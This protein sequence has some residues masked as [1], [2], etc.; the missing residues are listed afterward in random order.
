LII[1]APG[2]PN[3]SFTM[4]T[5]INALFVSAA[6]VATSAYASPLTPE[7]GQPAS[8][9]QVSNVTRAQVQE[10]LQVAKAAG[11]VTFGELEQPAAVAA[12]TSLTRDDVGLAA[13]K[14]AKNGAVSFG[15]S[16]NQPF[17]G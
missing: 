1:Q 5:L 4:K 12:S 10:E 13:V 6:L 17:Q 15:D 2:L 16:N 3:W 8:F 11:Q 9:T 7:G 14:A